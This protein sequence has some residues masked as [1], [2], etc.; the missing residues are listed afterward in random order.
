MYRYFLRYLLDIKYCI[1]DKI[2]IA[3]KNYFHEMWSM[4]MCGYGYAVIFAS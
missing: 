2:K 1:Q 3:I 4:S